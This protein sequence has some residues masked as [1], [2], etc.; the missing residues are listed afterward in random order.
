MI[1]SI[2]GDIV[3]DLI[4]TFS[5]SFEVLVLHSIINYKSVSRFIVIDLITHSD[6]LSHFVLKSLVVDS[7]LVAES[8]KKHHHLKLSTLVVD[9]NEQGYQVSKEIEDADVQLGVT[10]LHHAEVTPFEDNVVYLN[11]RLRLSLD[12]LTEL[13]NTLNVLF[14]VLS[15]G[16]HLVM[17]LK[18]KGLLAVA[19]KLLDM[20]TLHL[21]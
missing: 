19:L 6:K 15:F 21:V 17:E 18:P 12:E 3:S 1:H 14:E 10:A 2:L 9:L 20:V 16:K 5:H 4:E 8:T 7:T 11:Q 13:L